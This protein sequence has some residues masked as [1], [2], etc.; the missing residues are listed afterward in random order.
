LEAVGIDVVVLWPTDGTAIGKHRR[1]SNFRRIKCFTVSFTARLF[2]RAFVRV[3]TF[4]AAAR[5]SLAWNLERTFADVRT[6][7]RATQSYSGVATASIRHFSGYITPGNCTDAASARNNE[8]SS[9][10]PN[11]ARGARSS[12]TAARSDSTLKF[13][14]S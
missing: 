8:I 4:C 10:A 1:Q 5:Y 14:Q 3:H 12:G 7:E 9:H 11:N 2:E 13:K 6:N